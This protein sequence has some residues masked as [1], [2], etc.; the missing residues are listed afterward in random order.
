MKHVPLREKALWSLKTTVP[1]LITLS[2]R[3]FFVSV[4][5]WW[6][7]P[8][9]SFIK[10]RRL[11]FFDLLEVYKRK[12]SFNWSFLDLKE[13]ITDISFATSHCW[14]LLVATYRM[15]GLCLCKPKWYVIHFWCQRFIFAILNKKLC[16]YTSLRKQKMFLITLQQLLV[17]H[18]FSS[19]LHE[20]RLWK[21][22]FSCVSLS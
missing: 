13:R 7:P 10:A 6:C 2:T 19:S 4:V 1:L 16:R 21:F 22:V 18:S 14:K 5:S 3:K 15:Q 17:V 9:V 11:C 20:S 8:R 12:R